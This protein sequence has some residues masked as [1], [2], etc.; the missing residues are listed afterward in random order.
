MNL[1][2]K[3]QSIVTNQ[4]FSR[5]CYLEKFDQMLTKQNMLII[6]GQRRVGKSYIILDYLQTKNI[7]LDTVFYLNKELDTEGAIKTS[8]DLQELFDVYSKEHQVEY[9][10]IDEIQDIEHWEDF[11]REQLVYKKYKIV[12][13]GSNSKLLS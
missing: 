5:K 1:L 9:L 10:I 13:T 4:L 6:T 3:S 7:N 2:Q 8:Q 11:I 12:I